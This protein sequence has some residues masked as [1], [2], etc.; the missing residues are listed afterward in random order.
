VLAAA[1]ASGSTGSS[2]RADEVHESA[3][4]KYL[5]VVPDPTHLP[6]L[7]KRIR[8]P[9]DGEIIMRHFHS[10]KR[11]VLVDECPRCA[12]FWLD[13]GELTILAHRT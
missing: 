13:A 4:E 8:C 12:G 1:A 5:E 10:V 6:D 3:G 2:S 7:S 9:R 11:R